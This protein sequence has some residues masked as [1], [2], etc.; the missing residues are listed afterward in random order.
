MKK[1]NTEEMIAKSLIKIVCDFTAKYSGILVQMAVA[2]D[3]KEIINKRHPD[4][5]ASQIDVELHNEY[6]AKLSEVL[7]SFILVSEEGEPQIYPLNSVDPPEF[8]V[9]IDPLDTSELAVRGLCGYTQVLVYSLK[10]QIPIAGVVGDMFH[11]IQV[12]YAFR[13]PQ[14]N[15][16][17][18]LMTRDRNVLQIRSSQETNLHKAL[19]TGYSMRPQ[20]RFRKIAEQNTLLDA[21]AQPDENGQQRGRIGFDFGSMGLCHVAAGFT[22]AMIEIAKGFC[23]WDL[24]PGQY[25]LHAAGGITASLDGSVLPLNLNIHG[26]DDAGKLMGKRQKFVAAGNSTLLNS[27]LKTLK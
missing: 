25:I 11:T 2:N 4:N 23:I 16:H 7:P 21:L 3:R 9:I 12:Y 24:F 1:I 6:L 17:A 13:D 22:D 15:D 8:L 14:G 26:F 5:F 19:V 27:I 10:E 18:F 20:D